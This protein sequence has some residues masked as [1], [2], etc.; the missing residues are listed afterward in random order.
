MNL[1]RAMDVVLTVADQRSM[2]AAAK[3]LGT[4]LPTVVRILAELE[5]A[6]GVRLFNRTTRHVSLTEDG[7][8]YREHCR[9]ILAE[10]ETLDDIMAGSRDQPVGQ[11]S[12]TAPLCFGERH[13]A[14]VLARLAKENPGLTVRLFL[15]DR[16]VDIVEE[17]IDIAV[18]IGHLQDST[19]VAR[20]IG[21]V[22]PVLCASPEL[23]GRL[24]MPD[25]PRELSGLPCI[26]VFGNNAG[27][28]WP[29]QA[30]GKRLAVPIA[31]VFSC[32]TVQSAVNACID[33][34]GYGI[35]LSY[36]VKDAVG[37]GR[38]LALLDEFQPPAQPVSLVFSNA[39]LLTSRLRFVLDALQAGVRT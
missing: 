20:R 23:V 8:V 33:G 5:A 21:E 36:Q 34:A 11:V 28:T 17:H 1:L 35:F 24:G 13:V 32:N 10:V 37:D 38:L 7:E 4:S 22:R 19:L 18:R 31:G 16:V 2:T 3:K 12:V 25:H 9:R 15:A 26:Q 29:F 6:L 39:R 27:T 30:G 14:P